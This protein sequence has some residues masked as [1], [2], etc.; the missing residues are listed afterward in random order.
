MPWQNGS[1]YVFEAKHQTLDWHLSNRT[2]CYKT[3]TTQRM[4][5]LVQRWEINQNKKRNSVH[6]RMTQWNFQNSFI[7]TKE[8]R[9][10]RLSTRHLFVW[11]S[12]CWLTLQ[13]VLPSCCTSLGRDV[14]VTIVEIFQLVI[15]HWERERTKYYRLLVIMGWLPYLV[16]V[17]SLDKRLESKQ[18]FTTLF[19]LENLQSC[20]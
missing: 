6:T 13:K 5:W 15:P 19:N 14:A 16:F 17:V 1:V 7:I 11:R 20:K 3:G 9:D 8:F 4:Y 2:N 12:L 10:Q 18:S